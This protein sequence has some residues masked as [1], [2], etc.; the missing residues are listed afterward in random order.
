MRILVTGIGCPLGPVVTQELHGLGFAVA[1]I[2]GDGWPDAPSQVSVT[3][4]ELRSA[5][6]DE[7]LRAERPNA[8]V[9][10][11]LADPTATPSEERVRTNLAGMSGL[12][13]AMARSGAEQLV[14]LGSHCY[15]GAAPDLPLYHREWDPPHGLSTFPEFADLVGGDLMALAFGACCSRFRVCVLRP[16]FSLGR[17]AAGLLV[18]W[19]RGPRVPTVLGF[20]PLVQVLHE[21]DLARAAGLALKHG[22]SGA[23]NVGGVAPLPLSHLVSLA[24]ATAVPIPE[25]LF[26]RSLGRFHGLSLSHGAVNLFKYPVVVEDDVFRQRCQFAPELPLDSM[27][28][29][30]RSRAKD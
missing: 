10:L 12:L 17:S 27:L 13:Q 23:F 6:L 19:L 16:C 28:D 5:S 8:V 2:D 11:D 9:H 3:R 26:L 21:R 25:P 7:V 14:Y 18:R 24:G 30:L 29:E 1:G 22:L 20:D 4:I 15:Y